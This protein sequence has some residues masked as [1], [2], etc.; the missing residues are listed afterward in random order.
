MSGGNAGSTALTNAVL[1]GLA[2]S[3]V[4]LCVL[5]CQAQKPTEFFF[6]GFHLMLMMFIRTS[7]SHIFI[8]AV[9]E[10]DKLIS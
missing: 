9:S 1:R 7:L 3:C 4:F 10:I 6:G 8:N 5:L 2:N